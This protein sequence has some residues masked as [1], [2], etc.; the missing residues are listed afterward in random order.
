[1][2]LRLNA[3]HIRGASL[4]AELGIDYRRPEKLKSAN[5]RHAAWNSFRISRIGLIS[6]WRSKT[7]ASGLPN[8]E[9]K[10]FPLRASAVKPQPPVC[11]VRC[12]T[13]LNGPAG[14]DYGEGHS[15]QD[16]SGGKEAH[17]HR[18][19]DICGKVVLR[20]R[21]ALMSKA[22]NWIVGGVRPNR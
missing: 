7:D 1:L 17:V 12:G 22:M 21:Y 6:I 19:V 14:I 4:R 18:Q 3:E 2:T 15:L 9:T 5:L 10:T 8:E 11:L 13:V 16:R 20:I